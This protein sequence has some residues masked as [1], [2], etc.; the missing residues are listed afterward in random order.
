[1]NIFIKYYYGVRFCI[2]LLYDHFTNKNK[3]DEANVKFK[4]STIPIWFLV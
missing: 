4:I 1:M 3:N 2:H